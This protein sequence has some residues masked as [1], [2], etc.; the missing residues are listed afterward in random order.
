MNRVSVLQSER[1][2][3]WLK[4]WEDGQTNWHEDSF[5][6]ALNVSAYLI[7]QS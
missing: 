7:I 3:Y 5:D 2:E 4:K 6:L 1:P